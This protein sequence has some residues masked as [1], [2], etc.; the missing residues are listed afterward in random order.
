[1]YETSQL[2]YLADG[3][4]ADRLDVD[5]NCTDHENRSEAGELVSMDQQQEEYD[6]LTQI[7]QTPGGRLV[8]QRPETD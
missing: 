1:M 6:V 5:T 7:A 4:A 3:I 2:G 8:V